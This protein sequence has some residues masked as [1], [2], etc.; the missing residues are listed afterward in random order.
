LRLSAR[1][2]TLSGI[3]CCSS[4]ALYYRLRSASAWLSWIATGLARTL[5]SAPRTPPG[6]R[7]R[8]ADGTTVQRP[9]SR[10]KD[11]R[12]HYTLELLSLNCDWFELAEKG[13]ENLWRIPVQRGDLLMGDRYYFT[14]QGVAH[15]SEHGAFLLVRLG[16]NHP[17]LQTPEGKPFSAFNHARRLGVWARGEWPVR[18][19]LPGGTPVKGRVIATRL[20]AS[21]SLKTKETLV[22]RARHRQSRLHPKTLQAAP[23]VMLLTTLPKSRLTA[24][25]ALCVYRSRWQVELAFKRMK[26]LL[27][28]GLLPHKDVVA[29]RAWITSKL[30]VAL[31]LERLGRASTEQEAPKGRRSFRLGHASGTQSLAL[32]SMDDGSP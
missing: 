4:V 18:I 26:Q 9:G 32:D 13:S 6:L 8:I 11:W 3:A 10:A 2:L 31:L 22:R 5:S 15:V 12:L 27:G 14:H 29:G 28:L 19:P 24:K 20:P 16:W 21:K 17:A 25:Q 1:R 30:V 23:L 7:L